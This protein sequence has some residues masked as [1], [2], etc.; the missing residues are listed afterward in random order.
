MDDISWADNAVSELQFQC[1]TIASQHGIDTTEILKY[2]CPK[3]CSYRGN[4]V[5]GQCYC[6]EGTIKLFLYSNNCYVILKIS[7]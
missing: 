3:H 5:N 4:C 1:L 7:A 2:I 6:N